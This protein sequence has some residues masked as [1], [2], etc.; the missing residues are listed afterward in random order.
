MSIDFIKYEALLPGRWVTIVDQSKKP[1]ILSEIRVYGSNF[2]L[3]Q[4]E[5]HRKN[6]KNFPQFF[7]LFNLLIFLGP[8]GPLIEPSFLPVRLSR[9][10]QFSF[11]SSSIYFFLFLLLLHLLLL[12]SCQPWS[13][14]SPWCP[15]AP[16]VTLVV[17]VVVVM[18]V[19]F[20]F[21]A[22]FFFP[23]KNIIFYF[24]NISSSSSNLRIKVQSRRP[25][26]NNMFLLFL[27]TFFLKKN[28]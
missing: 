23:P 27:L 18:V 26:L 1:I 9:P 11:S 28:F 8:R 15:P 5:Q 19:Y 7:Y 10:Q 16:P 14:L 17:V 21:S 25:F 6:Y 24:Q 12:L 22:D 4:F 20:L 3:I 13:P 2:I